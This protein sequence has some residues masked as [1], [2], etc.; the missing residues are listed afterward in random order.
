MQQC[1]IRMMNFSQQ[2]PY[3]MTQQQL[4]DKAIDLLKQ[5]ISI[6]SFSSE[7]DKTADAIQ[8]WF[9]AFGIPFERIHNNVFAKNKFWDDSKPTL[10]LNS[11][12]DT[13]KPASG[14][15]KDPFNPEI[16]DGILYGLGSNDAGGSLVALIAT[17][18]H[19]Y[20]HDNLGYNLILVASAILGLYFVTTSTIS[21]LT[22]S[23]FTGVTFLFGFFCASTVKIPNK[24][25]NMRKPFFINFYFVG[26]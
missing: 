11:H 6:Q 21:V 13:V 5:L 12:H 26:L 8:E 24:I 19:L 16:T 23:I 9:Q 18:L 4:T 25:K 22:V 20:N 3:S 17:F 10:L 15:T 2:L 1:S 7:E 14:Y